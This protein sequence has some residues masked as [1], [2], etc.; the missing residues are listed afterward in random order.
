MTLISPTEPEP[1]CD[2]QAQLRALLDP[3]HPKRAVWIAEG[4]VFFMLQADGIADLTLP[5]QGTLYASEHDCGRLE[6]EPTEERL[7]EL[8]DYVEPKSG[9]IA[10][11]ALWYPVVQAR[12]ADDHVVWEQIASWKRLTETCQRAQLY[13]K[14]YILLMY[15][16]LQRRSRL[17]AAE[18]RGA[19]GE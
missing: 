14:R 1:I 8:L 10:Q 12:D 13:G 6:D 15:D 19:V 7:A 9:I 3:G 2:I 4:T 11:P 18:G 16:V 17:I 5:G